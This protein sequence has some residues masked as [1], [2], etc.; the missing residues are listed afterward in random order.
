ML[1]FVWRLLKQVIRAWLFTFIYIS[2]SEPHDD[3]VA[4]QFIGCTIALIRNAVFKA[5]LRFACKTILALAC[6]KHCVGMYFCRNKMSA[7]WPAATSFHHHISN[8]D[9]EK[10]GL[11]CDIYKIRCQQTKAEHLTETLFCQQKQSRRRHY[12]TRRVVKTVGCCFD[13][14]DRFLAKLKLW[15]WMSE[16]CMPRNGSHFKAPAGTTNQFTLHSHQVSV[17]GL[18]APISACNVNSSRFWKS[19]LNQWFYRP[20]TRVSAFCST[21]AGGTTSSRGKCV[22]F[23]FYSTSCSRSATGRS[24]L[25]RFCSTSLWFLL[26]VEVFCSTS[27][28]FLLGVRTTSCTS[29]WKCFLFHFCS[30]SA[31]GTS[32]SGDKCVLPLLFHV[33][34]SSA[35]S[36]NEHIRPTSDPL[37]AGVSVSCYCTFLLHGCPV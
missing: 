18:N 6:W 13:L 3:H 17:S 2:E 34:S 15:E 28:P 14:E 8:K 1:D 16:T 24:V 31:R 11:R 36:L 22:L 5:C 27:V 19:G 35:G 30:I 4:R 26:G 25:F 7:K 12:F 21:S 9:G 37:L 33:R 23:H 32:S 20:T 10:H 29:A